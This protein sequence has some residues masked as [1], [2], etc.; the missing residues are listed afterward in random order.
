MRK[1]ILLYLE[2]RDTIQPAHP[3]ET[4]KLG[5]FMYIIVID[6]S[7]VCPPVCIVNPRASDIILF[8]FFKK[9]FE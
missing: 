1:Y 3:Q 4:K 7:M 5:C 9:R 8:D 6:F 2:S